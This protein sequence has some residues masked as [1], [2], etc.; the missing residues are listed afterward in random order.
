[1]GVWLEFHRVPGGPTPLRLSLHD[2]PANPPADLVEFRPLRS[3]ASSAVIIVPSLTSPRAGPSNGQMNRRGRRGRR[4]TR[5][6]ARSKARRRVSAPSLARAC[7]VRIREND[8]HLGRGRAS[9]S[10]VRRVASLPRGSSSNPPNLLPEQYIE[11][12]RSG[13]RDGGRAQTIERA[14]GEGDSRFTRARDQGRG[15]AGLKPY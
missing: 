2:R 11:R 13:Q 1:M 5:K 10:V 14:D 9:P 8:Y 4:G 3:F 7:L 15:A 6:I 12:S